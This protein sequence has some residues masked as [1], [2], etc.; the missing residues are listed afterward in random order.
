MILVVVD[1][2]SQFAYFI[3]L[4]HLFSVKTVAEKFINRVVK[5]NGMPKSII[6]DRDYYL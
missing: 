2:L 4:S 6:R 1:K 3:S 5:L